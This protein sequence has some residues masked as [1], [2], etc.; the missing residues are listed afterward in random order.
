M[1]PFSTVIN[2][3]VVV[4]K[5]P[6]ALGTFYLSDLSLKAVGPNTFFNFAHIR[7]EIELEILTTHKGCLVCLKK[8]KMSFLTKIEVGTFYL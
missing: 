6:S 2:S 7:N 3:N 8:H 4:I 5:V 1:A